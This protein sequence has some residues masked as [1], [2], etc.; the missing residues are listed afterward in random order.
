MG[1]P[2]SPYRD[3]KPLIRRGRVDSLN[4]YEV[5]EQEL[6][7]LEK[8]AAGT[9]QFNFA[10]F[11]FSIALTCIT[12]LATADFKWDIVRSIFVFTTVV[13]LIVGS[14]LM[15]NWWR[16][17]TSLKEVISIIRSRINGQ[18]SDVQLPEEPETQP[19]DPEDSEGPNG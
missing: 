18:A 7:L 4:I 16:T 9:L 6:E 5:K 17:R 1:D 12:A 2:N 19:K 3:E 11:L 13:G 14:Y 15:L 10:I 8:G